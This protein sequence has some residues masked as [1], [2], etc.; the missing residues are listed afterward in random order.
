MVTMTTQLDDRKGNPVNSGDLLLICFPKLVVS[1]SGWWVSSF[2]R[3]HYR[4]TDSLKH[5]DVYPR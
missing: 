3:H 5:I 1:H 2:Y 4:L